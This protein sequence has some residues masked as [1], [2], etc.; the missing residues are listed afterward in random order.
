MTKV[1]GHGNGNENMFTRTQD[2]MGMNMMMLHAARHDDL[3]MA[4]C[5]RDHPDDGLII[6][7]WRTG[8]EL[9]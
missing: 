3:V 8:K 6:E 5:D 2:G 4:V 1:T 9:T 7:S